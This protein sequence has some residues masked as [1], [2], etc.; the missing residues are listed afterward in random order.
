MFCLNILLHC[1]FN[2]Y[3][4]QQDFVASKASA[5]TF[6]VAKRLMLNALGASIALGMALWAVNISDPFLLASLGGST[7][8]LFGLTNTPAAQPRALFGGHIGGALIGIICY[9]YF[10]DALWVHVLSVVLT[11][12]YMLATGTVHPPAGANPLLMVH[13]HAS[14]SVLWQPLGISLVVLTGAAF[15]WTRIVSGMFR[16]PVKLMDRSPPSILGGS[17]EK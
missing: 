12:I 4:M 8:F 14:F 1:N 15:I 9:Q 3:S 10:G 7:V 16:Y 2:F 11:L 13:N 6:K 5:G 17:W